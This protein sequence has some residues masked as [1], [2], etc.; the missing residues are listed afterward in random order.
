MAPKGKKRGNT[1]LAAGSQKSARH[2]WQAGT[3]AWVNRMLEAMALRPHFLT[4]RVNPVR[5]GII[6]SARSGPKEV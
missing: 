3:T 4:Y 1:A 2:E 5:E 6:L